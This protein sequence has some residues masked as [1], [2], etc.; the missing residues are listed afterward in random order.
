MESTQVSNQKKFTKNQ[1][2]IATLKLGE[3]Q[4]CKNGGLMSERSQMT[5]SFRNMGS[6]KAMQSETFGCP[7]T[8]G[9]DQV[10]ITER[11]GKVP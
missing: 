8:S 4:K 9:R 10:A 3:L 1:P 5:S 7:L 2:K 11:K 6:E